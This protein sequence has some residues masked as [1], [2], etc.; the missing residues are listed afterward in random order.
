VAENSSIEWTDTT[1]NPVTGCTKVSAGCDNCYA[2]RFSERFRGVLGHPFEN[3]FDLTLRPERLRQPL[4]WKRPRM[5]FVNS[6]S[7]LF[8]KA[9]PKDHIASVFDTM[10]RADW[11]IYQVLTKRSSLLQKFTN[12]RYKTRTA[13]PH[14]WCGVSVENA[15]ATSRIT[16]LQKTNAIIRFL[17][18]EPLIGPVGKLDLSGI[19]WV[20]VGGESGPGARPMRTH[21]AIDVRNQCVHAKVAFF[22]SSGAAARLNPAVVSWRARSGTNSQ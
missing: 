5:V 21:W 3:G 10:E 8:H 2:A 1:W 22:S 14:I 15:Q 13:P 6:M 9:V 18:M 20:I 12:E 11:H 16:H 19:N 17:S 4:A 7:D